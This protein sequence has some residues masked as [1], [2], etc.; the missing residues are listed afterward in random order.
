M[1]RSA[2]RDGLDTTAW[3]RSP[4][5]ASGLASANLRIALSVRDAVQDADVVVTM[6]SNANAVLSIMTEREGL[7][8]MKS[9]AVWIQMSTI[10]VE[11]TER[12]WRLA[13]IRPEIGFL[14][15]PVSGS[16][17]A[18]EQGKLVILA[19]GDQARAG[20]TA[21]PF[22]MRSL[23]RHIGSAMWD[24]EPHETSVQRLDRDL[25]GRGRGSVHTWGCTHDRPR[26]FCVT[27]LRW[28]PGS[29]RG[30][31]LNCRR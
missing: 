11:G 21:Q 10:G 13:G 5:R 7:A 6:V 19:S 26:P 23:R 22:S 3:D 2:A 14:D 25:D 20:A 9:G 17:A 4:G 16:K 29:R 12:A 27:G 1:A 18:A 8:A 15:A 28:S 30:Q 24:R 31:W